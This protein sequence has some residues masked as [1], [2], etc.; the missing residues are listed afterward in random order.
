M[1]FAG[2]KVSATRALELGCANAVFENPEEWAQAWLGD[3]LRGGPLALR[4]AKEAV[5]GGQVLP[6]ARALDHERDCYGQVLNSTDRIEGL[7]AFV[8]KRA[9]IYKG[10]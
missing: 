8:E 6:I 1:I 7:K 3:V 5:W 10:Q 9:P 4:A 2:R